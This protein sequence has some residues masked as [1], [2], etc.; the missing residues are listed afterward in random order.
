M[1]L[2]IITPPFSFIQFAEPGMVCSDNARPCLPLVYVTDLGFRIQIRVSGD[3]REA[4]EGYE[5]SAG[6]VVDCDSPGIIPRNYF[7]DWYLVEPGDGSDPDLWEG[8]FQFNDNGLFPIYEVG[9]CLYLAIFKNS[10]GSLIDCL[11]TCFKKS[12]D[13]CYSTLLRYRNNEDAFGFNYTAP[14]NAFNRVRLPFYLH[15]PVNAEEEKSY[16]KSDGSSMLISARLYK[17]YKVTSDYWPEDWIE[18]FA[19]ATKHDTVIV[20]NDYAGLDNDG[21]LRTDALD[22]NWRTE[23]MPTFKLAQVKTTMRLTAARSTINNNCQ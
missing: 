1:G 12:D 8:V 19:V 21:V 7:A 6:F 16:A 9:Q 13:M 20:T 3:D 14:L 17:D 23:D 10:D 22:I 2:G 4:F 18:K 5:V 15:S 11:E